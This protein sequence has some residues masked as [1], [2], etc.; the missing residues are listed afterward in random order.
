MD[1]PDLAS[2]SN[3]FL[4]VELEDFIREGDRMLSKPGKRVE[5]R[6]IMS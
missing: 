4:L 3:S 1:S 6:S 5:Q 2:L